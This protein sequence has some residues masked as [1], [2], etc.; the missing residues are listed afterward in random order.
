MKKEKVVYV[1]RTTD[2][3]PYADLKKNRGEALLSAVEHMECGQFIPL[4]IL[5]DDKKIPILEDVKQLC[6]LREDIKFLRNNG[7]DES[8]IGEYLEYQNDNGEL[9]A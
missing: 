4:H 6:S 7:I 5:V 8:E 9:N 3:I 2:G 1:Y